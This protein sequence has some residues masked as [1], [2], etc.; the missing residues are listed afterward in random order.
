M[1][2]SLFN[3]MASGT[4]TKALELMVSAGNLDADELP[5]SGTMII[6]D[7]RARLEND[8]DRNKRRDE[9][10]RE[11]EST[12]DFIDRLES[13]IEEIQEEIER[14]EVQRAEALRLA[15]E[16]FALAIEA[17]EMIDAIAD[18]VSS[19]ERQRLIELLGP[20]AADATPDELLVLLETLRDE[21]NLNG[22]SQNAEAEDV[23]SILD[24]KRDELAK[25]DAAKN[26][27]FENLPP[28]DAA[29]L[30]R[31]LSNLEF[32]EDFTDDAVPQSDLDFG[33]PSPS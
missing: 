21:N 30:K 12:R 26:I 7:A 10:I 20:V 29:E 32:N 9:L 14:L 8:T 33:P 2:K 31:I 22:R 11:L 13:R 17:D 3:K 4:D 28:L 1:V 23:E 15:E 18:D 6:D 27:G 19:D 5:L 16:A 24:E 25:L